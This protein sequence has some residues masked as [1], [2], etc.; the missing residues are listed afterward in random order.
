LVDNGALMV[1]DFRLLKQVAKFI[2]EK[3]VYVEP[4]YL[5]NPKYELN[6]KS[7]IYSLGVLL[8]ELSSGRPPLNEE[9]EK[10]VANTPLKYLLLYQKCW[11]DDPNLRPEINE[12]YEILSKLKLQS[13]TD[14]KSLSSTN[15][16]IS[17]QSSSLHAAHI[18]LE[19]FKS[20]KQQIIRQ[21]KLNH[22]IVVNKY[23]IIPS[24]QGVAFEDGEFEVN[25]YKGYPLVYTSINPEDNELK[26]DTCISFP[27]A[28]IV[29]NGNL[30][31]SFSEY[32]NDEKKLHELYGD[33]LVRKFLAGGQLF[34]KNFKSATKTQADILKF[35]LF[36]IYNSAK[37]SIEIQFSNLFTLDL[38]PKLVTLNGEKIN[39]HEKLTNLMNNLYLKKMVN[40]ISYDDLI[41]ISHN[42]LLLDGDHEASGE[43][44][45]G[46][47][48]PGFADSEEKLSLNKWVRKAI[49]NN[50]MSWTR[51]FNLF[52]GLII[53][54][55]DE[56][57]ISKKIPVDFIEIPGVNSINK[58]YLKISEPSTKLEFTLIF[59]NIFSIKNLSAFPFIKNNNESYEGYNH[60]LVK[61]EKY[62]IL[63]NT[64]SIKPTKDFEQ[65]IEEAL[66]G[67]MPLKALQDVHDEYGHLFPQRIV[68]GRSLKNVLQ[69]LTSSN[70]FDDVNDNDKILESLNNLNVS[71][72]LTQK[73]KIIEKNV[74]NNWIHNMDNQLEIIEYDN[75]IPLYK[76]LKTEQQEKID[77]ILK[78]N[79]RIIMTGI[80]DLTGLNN[81]NENYIRINFGLSLESED[82]QIFGSIIS[83]N[84]T[85]LEEFYVNFGLYDF[86]GFYA[87]IKK[88]KE[89]NN[90]ITKCFVLWIIIGS[91]SKLSIFS[92]NNRELQVE[93]IKKSIKL[94]PNMLNYP[95]ETSFTLNEGYTVL[96]RA[97]HSSINYEP[98]NIIKLIKW[99]ERSIN[100]QIESAYK[101]QSNS[102]SSIILDNDSDQEDNN[103]L[104][105]E[106]DLY[107]CFLSTNYKSL[108]IDNAK[109][110]KFPLDLIGYVLKEEDYDGTLNN[111]FF[112]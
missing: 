13:V 73:G 57:E 17:D 2:P 5:R 66:N 62:E 109:E 6:M 82:Y 54:K 111:F 96:A 35:Y 53:N 75:I 21:F 58:S 32:T 69:N 93:F 24:V 46:E 48:Q 101:I 100:I 67:V 94:Q 110:R 47:K 84:N 55:Y 104:T 8:W 108:E 16:E 71:Y 95:I 59:N 63:L 30:L 11:Q 60:V 52:Q 87:I 89:T 106:I 77:D 78:D 10:P 12:V 80:T 1:T 44:Q 79:F 43:K 37:Y 98:N 83:E 50:L 72:L 7:D 86:D 76:I 85:K 68:L 45:S 105:N 65:D 34:I 33:F 61:C 70:T 40:I 36:C 49:N 81:D 112:L 25:S 3:E 51:D 19:I 74:L 92:P 9:R 64:N 15:K 28:E 18:T 29:N 41:P 22:G 107:M 23:D 42:M 56:I 4:Q 38:L 91:P 99:K 103:S 102:N 27:V 31:Q 90:H 26:I 20:S 14:G 97:N 39:T 88:V